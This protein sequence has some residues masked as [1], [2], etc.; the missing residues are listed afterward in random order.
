ASAQE[1]ELLVQWGKRIADR[2]E[3]L[4]ASIIETRKKVRDATLTYLRAKG[5]SDEADAL[6]KKSIETPKEELFDKKK[7]KELEKAVADSTKLEGEW[8]TYWGGLT[9][10]QQTDEHEVNVE[11]AMKAKINAQIALASYVGQDITAL[12]A[13][14]TSVKAPAR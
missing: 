1:K 10:E 7:L 14:F 9:R 13:E 8:F 5:E 12:Q 6:E 4:K 2:T 3:K 11:N